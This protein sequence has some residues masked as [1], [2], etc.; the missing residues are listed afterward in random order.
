MT[1]D[2]EKEKE[3]AAKEAVKF[4]DNNQIV[5]LG[6]GSTAVYAVKEIGILVKNGLKIQGVPTSNKTKE[7][8]E[9]LN[10][11]LVDINTID[12]IDITIDGADEFNGDLVLIKG[13]GGALLKEKI[14]ASMT[15]KEII[16]ADSSKKA[17]KIGKFPLPIEVIPFAAGYVLRKLSQINGLGK[18][19]IKDDSPFITDEG[20]YIIDTDFG[21]I[22]DP[23]YLS[24][25]LNGIE[26][27]VA[28]GLFIKLA[29]KVIMG[30]SDTNSTTTYRSK[31]D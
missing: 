25:T 26:G 29:S 19:R 13:G 27:V 8:A 20:N 7:L 16:I 1:K 3:L 21:F 15:K 17:D 22:T 9:T 23:V 6:T 31:S 4:I 30:V 2:L 12:S 5:G 10:I 24:H 11:P 14:V 18:I 28:H